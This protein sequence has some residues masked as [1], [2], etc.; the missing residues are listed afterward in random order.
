L[1][2]V[3]RQKKKGKREKG[4]FLSKGKDQ[5][6]LFSDNAKEKMSRREKTT[7][8]LYPI[9]HVQFLKEKEQFEGRG[10]ACQPL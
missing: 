7:R 5:R 6:P 4:T 10:I 2:A 9:S 1:A 3:P 8:G